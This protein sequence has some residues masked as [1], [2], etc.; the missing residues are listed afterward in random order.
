[1]KF[2]EWKKIREGRRELAQDFKSRYSGIP[3]DP[4][5]HP[6]G[7]VL[8]HIRLVRRAIPKAVS[9]LK[10]LQN[11]PRFGSILKDIDFKLTKDESKILAMASWL[12]DVGKA[13][14]TTIDGEIWSPDSKLGD[15]K[16]QAIGHQDAK[17]YE[18]ELEMLSKNAPK[19]TV[20]FYKQ[21][22]ELI[23][24]LI[25]RHMDFA[26]GIFPKHVISKFFDGAK[27]RNHPWIK[28]LLILMWADKLGTNPIETIM[29]SMKRNQDALFASSEK[30]AKKAA[31]IARQKKSF[32][33]NPQDF[34]SQLG[35]KTPHQKR[36]A[37]RGKYPHLDIKDIERLVP[38]NFRKF[39]EMTSQPTTMKLKIT[40]PEDCVKIAKALVDVDPSNT[41]VYAVGGAVRDTLLGRKPKDVDLTTNLDAEEITKRLEDAGISIAMKNS[42]TF[43]VVF[44]NA[45]GDEPVEVAGF[46][47]DVGV[48]DGRRPDEIETNVSME[49]DAMRRD[50]TMNN[51]YYDFGYGKYGKD[52]V[53]DFNQGGQGI[54]DAKD[55]VARPV[56]DPHERFLEDR[57]RIL[58][59]I[60]FFSRFNSGDIMDFL[61]EATRQSIEKLGS[62]RI[63]YSEG[64][65]NLAPI[66][67]ERIQD[68]FMKGLKTSQNLPAYLMNYHRLDMM[69]TV[70]PNMN[71]N[72]Q[73]INRLGVNMKNPIVVLAWLLKDNQNV[74]SQLNKLNWPNEITDGV[75]AVLSSF[76]FDD[77]NI[78]S[79]DKRV[80]KYRR[81]LGDMAGIVEDPNVADKLSHLSQYQTEFPGGDE[82]M[83][84]PY[85]IPRGPQLGQKQKELAQKHYKKS[86]DDF[87]KR[88]SS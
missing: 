49:A 42:D 12:H 3:Q 71:V 4:H 51:L 78:K 26:T 68:E 21:N 59:L 27:V 88:K 48:S 38:E 44:A 1:M 46:R 2:N 36:Q 35:N 77:S 55:G 57:I 60:R 81:D 11:H 70:F 7:D 28:L 84:A 25:Q 29:R 30:S 20:D 73:G 82:L 19:Q 65:V 32:Q 9:E 37:L 31:N 45:G 75:E 66:S 14:S 6:E 13:T 41:E 18:P 67:G 50:L 64:N 85:N 80:S 79:H 23:D 24:F 76:E 10:N 22:K 52:L 39:L 83:K 56:G 63:P 86:W 54:K 87:L 61:D 8:S 58:R 69:K 74:G 53:I 5:H 62:L 34:L 16:I 33:G 40:I 15:G 43:N 72:V 17:H 47:A